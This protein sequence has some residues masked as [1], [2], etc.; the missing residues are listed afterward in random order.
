MGDKVRCG[1]ILV[2][3]ASIIF[4]LIRGPRIFTGTIQMK[5]FAIVKWTLRT[6]LGSVA[7][8][9][10]R[11]QLLRS[12]AVVLFKRLV[13]PRTGFQIRQIKIRLDC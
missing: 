6:V 5:F 3:T 8:F 10:P 1:L 9:Q 7:L 11:F 2:D 4:F 12:Q 13:N